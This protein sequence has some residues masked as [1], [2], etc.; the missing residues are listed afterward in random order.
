[1]LKL[2][3]ADASEEFALSLSEALADTYEISVCHRGGEV[4]ELLRSIRP[5]LLVLDMMLPEMD[6]ITLL[7]Q[8]AG[9][10]IHPTVLAV[11][12]FFNDYVVSSLESL[13][14]GYAMRKPCDIQGTVNRLNDLASRTEVRLTA[15]Y[16]P[17]AK[18]SELLLRMGFASGSRGY[19]ALREGILMMMK[20][21]GCSVSKEIYP[22]VGSL[23]GGNAGQAERAIRTA[24]TRAWK[25]R[26][27]TVWD[28]LFYPG[29]DEKCPT[30]KEF[31]CRI[32]D[33]LNRK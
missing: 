14:V 25:Y 1:M 4:P 3:I 18:V 21:P 19:P 32:A 10:G 28:R 27:K 29:E 11:S 8:A 17:G 31:I 6:G 2:L 20:D 13:G 22:R 23:A 30:N 9:E 15:P 12:R 33:H 26:D 16:D 24:I 5:D 7:H